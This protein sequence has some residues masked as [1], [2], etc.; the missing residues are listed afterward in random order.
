MIIVW[1]HQWKDILYPWYIKRFFYFVAYQ[2]FFS[3]CCR[4]NLHGQVVSC[5]WWIDTNEI[6]I[7]NQNCRII[8]YGIKIIICP[9]IMLKLPI[10]HGWWYIFKHQFANNQ[11]SFMFCKRMFQD[12]KI[13]ISFVGPLIIFHARS[14]HDYWALKWSD[15]KLYF[16]AI[17]YSVSL[18]IQ[19]QYAR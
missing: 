16:T 10:N 9:V 13:F 15:P 17:K 8:L 12:F 2:K 11:K 5:V 1:I 18:H 7:W 4:S 14:V 3:N 6:V 19:K